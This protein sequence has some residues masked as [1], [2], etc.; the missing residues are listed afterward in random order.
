[1][2]AISGRRSSGGAVSTGYGAH[3]PA[4]PVAIDTA[5]RATADADAITRT[6]S[7]ELMRTGLM[8]VRGP[9]PNPRAS[10]ASASWIELSTL[11][12]TTGT[13][14]SAHERGPRGRHPR[15]RCAS[16]TWTKV[17]PT[18]GTRLSAAATAA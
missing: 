17:A 15:I 2:H 10:I 12:R 13:A 14:T 11:V 9:E 18:A 1:M 6:Q 8:C 5:N 3:G 16:L 4:Q 7:C